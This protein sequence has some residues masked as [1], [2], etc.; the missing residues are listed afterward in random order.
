M[1]CDLCGDKVDHF[2]HSCTCG[3]GI[4][5]S[6][7]DEFRA[8]YNAMRQCFWWSCE[9]YNFFNVSN[10]DD[11]TLNAQ[12][13]GSLSGWTAELAE[14]HIVSTPSFMFNELAEAIREQED[15]L[16][17][18]NFTGPPVIDEFALI[19]TEALDNLVERI[20]AGIISPNEAR[21]QIVV[22]SVPNEPI[23]DRRRIDF[24]RPMDQ[25]AD[26]IRVTERIGFAGDLLEIDGIVS[27]ND[28][29]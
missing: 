19:Q 6:C 25:D 5:H 26:E 12:R 1:K 2:S 21:N 28:I 17:G 18:R 23:G 13:F 22:G 8:K 11:I 20:R 9:F 24:A 10:Y 27:V 7:E 14:D 16:V 29:E 3:H 4:C 15:Q